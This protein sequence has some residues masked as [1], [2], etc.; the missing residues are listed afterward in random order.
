MHLYL[1]T[2]D[3]FKSFESAIFRE[4]IAL[5]VSCRDGTAGEVVRIVDEP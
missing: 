3:C 5:M 4:G 1:M 2:I